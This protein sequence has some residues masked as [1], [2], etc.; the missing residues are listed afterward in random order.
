MLDREIFGGVLSHL[1]AN[2]LRGYGSIN[3]DKY[4]GKLTY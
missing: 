1:F 3:A 4:I 2:G